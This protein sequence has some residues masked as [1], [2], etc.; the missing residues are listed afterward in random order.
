MISCDKISVINK[1]DFLADPPQVDDRDFP[2]SESKHFQPQA[3]LRE[4]ILSSHSEM[5]TL[6]KVA[7]NFQ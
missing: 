4:I 6:V 1:E 2:G 3:L 7:H 5:E